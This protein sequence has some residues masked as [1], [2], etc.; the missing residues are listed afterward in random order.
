M[1][2]AIAAERTSIARPETLGNAGAATVE[3]P[4]D[5]RRGE[6]PGNEAIAAPYAHFI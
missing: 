5:H 6:T 3:A 2:A 4:P 1:S